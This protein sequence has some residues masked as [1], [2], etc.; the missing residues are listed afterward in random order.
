MR[1]SDD[2]DDGDG[3]DGVGR[4]TPGLLDYKRAPLNMKSERTESS[5]SDAQH[6]TDGTG[7]E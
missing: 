1:Q 4:G 3:G 7:N 6:K 2:V 5:T